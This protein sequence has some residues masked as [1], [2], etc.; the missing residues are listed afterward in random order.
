MVSR[1]SGRRRTSIAAETS[2]LLFCC[3]LMWGVNDDR[4]SVPGLGL[5]HLVGEANMEC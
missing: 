4:E 3:T 2:I 5:G 1:S